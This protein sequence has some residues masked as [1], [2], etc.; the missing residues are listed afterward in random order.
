MIRNFLT[1][2]S[3]LANYSPRRMDATRT[4][5]KREWK[6]YWVS[7]FRNFL[8]TTNIANTYRH[9]TRLH[10]MPTACM[11]G[12]AKSMD[13]IQDPSVYSLKNTTNQF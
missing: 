2:L 7:Y 13:S 12:E 1:C 11:G 4:H 6:F 5:G 9:G 10:N 8:P 3:F